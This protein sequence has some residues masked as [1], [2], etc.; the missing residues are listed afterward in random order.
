MT[1]ANGGVPVPAL[2]WGQPQGG[3]RLGLAAD[4]AQITLALENIGKQPLEVLS[5]VEAGEIHL[6]W[7]TLHVASGTAPPRLIH[8]LDD[9][10]ESA[11]IRATLAPQQR[12]QHTIDLQAWASRPA[13]GGAPF[14]PGD[15][16]LNATYSVTP[17]GAVWAGRL[18]AGPVAWVVRGLNG[19][20]CSGL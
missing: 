6:D 4:G 16:Q 8:L 12:L 3:L 2:T 14:P 17:R 19:S 20:Q 9:R 11:I 1:D 13:N 10:D 18:E 7:Y 15:Y 5:H